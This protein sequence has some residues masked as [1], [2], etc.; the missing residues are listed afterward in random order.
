MINYKVIIKTLGILLLFESAFMILAWGVSLIYG[1]H[2]R[3]GFIE[4]IGIAVVI[5]GGMLLVSRKSKKQLQ[6]REGYIIVSLV[7]IVFSL[8][9]ALPFFLSGAIPS[10]TDAFFETIS[11]FT[12]TGA[13]ILND[14]EALPHGLLFW[15]SMTQWLGGMGIIVLSLTILPLLGIGGMQLF[16]A[17]VPGPTAD[18]LHPRIR[19]TAKRLW[20]I[21][22]IFTTAQT[23]LLRLGGM[24]WFDAINHA[25]TTMATG[26]YSTKQASVAYYDSAYIQY[27]ITFFMFLAGTSFTLSYFALHAKFQK[28]WKN[29]EFRYYLGFTIG[30]SLVIATVLYFTENDI[31]VEQSFRDA[32]F[33]VV[34]I[35]TTTGFATADYLLWVP[36]LTVLTF[37]IMFFGGSAGSC[38]WAAS[39]T[40]R[41]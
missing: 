6:E 39:D 25:F 1:E 9:G 15:R 8:F 33:Q 31:T 2:D 30:F 5:G 24:N 17:E 3:V 13:S 11:G 34:S 21:Y 12:T 29:E 38:Q 18:K 16:I 10:Y 7:W 37:I 40:R 36:F 14:I 20:A 27:V 22:L 28:V 26:G 4:S 23:I 35:M 19:E 41:S 32:I